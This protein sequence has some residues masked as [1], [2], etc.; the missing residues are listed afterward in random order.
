MKNICWTYVLIDELK[1]LIVLL[2][3]KSIA[4]IACL[5]QTFELFDFSEKKW[6]TN[7]TTIMS[8]DEFSTTMSFEI[9]FIN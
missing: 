2:S 3:F 9:M 6:F 1:E 7:V 4:M 5:V 8:I